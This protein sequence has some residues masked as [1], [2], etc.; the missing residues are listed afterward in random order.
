MLQRE[1]PS[2][3]A[4]GVAKSRGTRHRSRHKKTTLGRMSTPHASVARA[5]AAAVGNVTGAAE[6]GELPEGGFIIGVVMGI[7]G[8]IGINVGQNIRA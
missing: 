7:F 3:L 6:C 5:L 4:S 2:R 8:S 1:A